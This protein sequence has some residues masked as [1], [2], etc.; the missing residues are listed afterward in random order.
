[1]K[2]KQLLHDSKKTTQRLIEMS[3]KSEDNTSSIKACLV[4][5]L[6][7]LKFT[8]HKQTQQHLEKW[9]EPN[10]YYASSS[11]GGQHSEV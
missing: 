2:I 1:M 9:R 8:K 4:K 3:E 6:Q 7:Q 10:L 5:L 11:R